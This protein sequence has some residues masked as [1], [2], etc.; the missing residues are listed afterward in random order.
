MRGMTG[1]FMCQVV[2]LAAVGLGVGLAVYAARV[3]DLSRPMTSHLGGPVPSLAR[4]SSGVAALLV[5]ALPCILFGLRLLLRPVGPNDA[6]G[7]RRLWP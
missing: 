3:I 4:V 1:R 5:I 2:G 7:R 6:I